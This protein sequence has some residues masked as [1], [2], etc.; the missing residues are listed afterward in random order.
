MTNMTVCFWA[1][2]EVPTFL[3]AGHETTS[4]ATTWCLYALTQNTSIQDKLREELLAVPTDMPSMEE[5]NALPYLDS[6]IRE[7]LRLHTPV[8][9]TARVAEK[10]DIIPLSEP[11]KDK[12][13]NLLHEIPLVKGNRV[14]IP[15]L[16]LHRMKALWG[17][18]AAEFRFVCG[19]SAGSICL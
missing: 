16:A 1:L 10:D 8:T 14:Q 4:T 9:I 18:D 11:V 12:Y 3:V 2:V 17:E 19:R 7:T 5:L 6:V 15:I 13:G